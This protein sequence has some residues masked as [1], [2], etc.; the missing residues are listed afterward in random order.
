MYFHDPS[1]ASVS[2][3]SPFK[4]DK[5][6][7]CLPLAPG[8]LL[9]LAVSHI[10]ICNSERYYY[11]SLAKAGREGMMVTRIWTLCCPSALLRLPL[12]SV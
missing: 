6:P 1:C 10:G 12:L 9:Q 2:S 11:Y 5:S 4:L 7:A 8:V 3:L